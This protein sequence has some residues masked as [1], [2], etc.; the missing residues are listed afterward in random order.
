MLRMTH[1]ISVCCGL[2]A[3]G[4]DKDNTVPVT[5]VTPSELLVLRFIHGDN[6]VHDL[7]FYDLPSDRERDF[8]LDGEFQRL[9]EKYPAR[10][11]GESKPPV[12]EVFPDPR[13]GYVHSFRECQIPVDC[14]KATGRVEIPEFIDEPLPGEDGYT[15]EDGQVE[16]LGV[17]TQVTDGA[18]P[19][20]GAVAMATETT[21]APTAAEPATSEAEAPAEKVADKPAKAKKAPKAK[22]AA[23]ADEDNPLA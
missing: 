9:L 19:A 2:L 13:K 11:D 14:L 1:A 3:L 21:P 15:G 20:E 22:P 6:A 18:S 17:E 23:K 16:P 7:E 10:Q 8:P 5:D 12:Q 4:G